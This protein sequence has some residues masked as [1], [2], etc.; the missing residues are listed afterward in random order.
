MFIF[1]QIFLISLA[2]QIFTVVKN[3]VTITKKCS[4]II[5]KQG[6]F[7]V[8]IILRKCIILCYEIGFLCQN[9]IYEKIKNL[10]PKFKPL[11][12]DKL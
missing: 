2:K 3:E 4:E 8:K 1:E 9:E 5:T 10:S 7:S 6:C 11:K 12:I